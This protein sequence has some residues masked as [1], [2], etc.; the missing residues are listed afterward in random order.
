MLGV[1][2]TIVGVREGGSAQQLPSVVPT[3]PPSRPLEWRGLQRE[4][5]GLPKTTTTASARV[6]V[7]L[8]SCA[9]CE[10]RIRHI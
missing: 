10:R 8:V 2:E 6:L 1:Q 9:G 3:M 5:P 7:L 4:S